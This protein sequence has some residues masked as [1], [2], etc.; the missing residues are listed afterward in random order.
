MS[1]IY[2][3]RKVIIICLVA[4]FA[5]GSFTSCKKTKY[6]C[7]DTYTDTAGNVF[8]STTGKTVKFFK[9]ETSLREYQSANSKSC[10]IA[11]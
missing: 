10:A 3:M 9:D 5:V 6:Y 11:K 4:C 7:Y 2:T 1:K 8:A